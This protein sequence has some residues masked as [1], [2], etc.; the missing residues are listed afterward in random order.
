M[1][2]CI[3]SGYHGLRNDLRNHPI[4]L[5]PGSNVLPPPFLRRAWSVFADVVKS[6]AREMAVQTRQVSLPDLFSAHL[7]SSADS[8]GLHGDNIYIYIYPIAKSMSLQK[9]IFNV[10]A[11]PP[12]DPWPPL[13]NSKMQVFGLDD[14]V[15]SLDDC[16]EFSVVL[17]SC[18]QSVRTCF[19]K[20]II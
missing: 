1:I 3:F 12:K 10:L 9:V 17:K 11:V 4:T 2:A 18:P 6:E 16:K 15:L 7:I 13:I 19:S 5:E 20:T 8:V 14:C